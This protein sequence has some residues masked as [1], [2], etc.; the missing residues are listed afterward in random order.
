M[1]PY[2]R[3]SSVNAAELLSRR[4]R[5][6]RDAGTLNRHCLKLLRGILLQVMKETELQNVYWDCLNERLTISTIIATL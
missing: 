5:G 4:S 6:I 1:A 2:R 3:K